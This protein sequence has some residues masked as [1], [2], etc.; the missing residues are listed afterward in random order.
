VLQ[1]REQ[2]II[3][4][5]KNKLDEANTRLRAE[6]QEKSAI[7]EA[8]ARSEEKLARAFES[9]PMA[10]AIV[11]AKDG[12]CLQLNRQFEL[13]TGFSGEQMIGRT[14]WDA[15]TFR[16]AGSA[17]KIE[18]Y[19]HHPESSRRLHCEFRT[20]AG[21]TRQGIFWTELFS[22]GGDWHTLAILQDISEQHA[23]EQQLRQAQKMEA[24]GHLAAGV[25]HDFNNLLTVIQGHAS[26]HTR[27]SAIDQRIAYSFQQVSTAAERAAELTR[28]LLTF[29]RKK[30]VQKRALRLESI[31]LSVAPMLQRLIPE[32]IQIEFRHAAKAPAILADAGSIE[33]A[34]LNLVVNARDAMPHGGTILVETALV[35]LD[36]TRRAQ[37]A[38]RR[39]GAFMCLTVRDSGSGI[40]PETLPHIFEPFYTTKAFGKGSGMGLASVYGIIAQHDGWIEVQ[41]ELRQGTAF[42][43]Y[44]PVA[45][46]EI[47][48]EVTPELVPIRSAAGETILIAEDDAAVRELARYVLEEQGY[49]VLE[50]AT[51]WEAAEVSRAYPGPIDL[52][53]TD[54]IMPGGVSGADLAEMIAAARPKTRI[55]VSSGYSMELLDPDFELARGVSYLP[56][57]YV[58]SQLLAAIAQMLPA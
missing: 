30:I 49:H 27:S 6:I 5:E 34:L 41:S 31:V 58:A 20:K 18:S 15:A 16:D 14:F 50:G 38:E 13:T 3:A 35:T 33:Q 21:A 29:S 45:E 10:V 39:A 8:L 26:L 7:Q 57:P 46:S 56:K 28:Q 32:H 55:I 4:R 44:L 24:V 54:M 9:F 42:K 12:A 48:P 37:H 2:E 51:G 17:A 47:V 11:S 22:V 19:L 1:R 36:E 40:S 25:A 53:V 43:I 52:L 23:L